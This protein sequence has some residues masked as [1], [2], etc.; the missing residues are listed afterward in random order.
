MDLTDSAIREFLTF[1]LVLSRLGGIFL[2]APVLGGP[3]VPKRVRALIAVA[4]AF[5]LTPIIAPVQAVPTELSR[6]VMGLVG[7]VGI[8][9]MCGFI[10]SLSFAAAQ[11][12]G[13]LI[14]RQ[15]GVSLGEIMNPLYESETP[16]FGQFYFLFALVVFVAIN[17]HYV[18][19]SGLV[20]SFE[21]VPVMGAHL[22]AGMAPMM[23]ALMQE[24]FVLVIKLAAPAFAALFLVTIALGLAARALPQVNIMF[25]GLPLQVLVGLLVT[26]L[27]LG[28]AATLLQ[29]N[30]DVVARHVDAAVRFMAS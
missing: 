9:L 8:G 6:L 21:R 27:A 15:M 5:A 20:H 7:E 25:V 23:G 26:G 16:V 11:M 17:G 12:A 2:V 3:A 13:E 28:G 4:L 14:A 30:L 19:V 1:V 22:H 10:V 24:M 29:R 18:L